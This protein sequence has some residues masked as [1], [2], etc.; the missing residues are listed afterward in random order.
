M[1]DLKKYIRFKVNVFQAAI[2]SV[3]ISG[4]ISFPL[5]NKH[6]KVLAT[7]YHRMLR[8]VVAS[9]GKKYMTIA[10]SNGVKQK[11]I[12]DQEI[13]IRTY[14]KGVENETLS[15][16]TGITACA[17][18]I[19]KA[20]EVSVHS[21]GGDLKVRF[22]EENGVYANILLGGPAKKVFTGTLEL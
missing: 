17:L 12:S 16:G 22:T 11:V 8:R 19:G 7:N 10:D 20:P 21:E 6:I 14:E 18:T 9:H 1:E 3:L 15:C 13:R 5:S 2:V 4:L